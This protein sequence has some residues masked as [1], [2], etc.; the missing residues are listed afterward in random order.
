MTE[1]ISMVIAGLA[2]LA[3]AWFFVAAV[4][5]HDNLNSKGKEKDDEN[6]QP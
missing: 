6:Q 4:R 2:V 3:A 5:E 1:I